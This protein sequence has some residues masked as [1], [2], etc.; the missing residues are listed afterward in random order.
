MSATSTHTWSQDCCVTVNRSLH[1]VLFKVNPSLCQAF[2]QVIDVTNLC[3]VHTLLHNT[4]N[5]TIYGPFRWSIYDTFDAFLVIYH[6]NITFSLFRLSLDSVETLIRWGW[7][8]SYRHMHRSSLI[9]SVKTE[10]KS[11]D[12]SRSLPIV[13][14]QLLSTLSLSTLLLTFYMDSTYSSL[15]TPWAIKN[16][17]N[18]FLS[19]TSSNINK[20]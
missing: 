11:V 1:N 19:V 18:L 20:F 10:L 16:V 12:F 3:S 13:K 15:T 2:L 14:L 17:A 5:F 4:P 6:C 9:L 8:S 7:W